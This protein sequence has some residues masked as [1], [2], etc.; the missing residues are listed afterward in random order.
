MRA[1]VT[2][3]LWQVVA[4]V[5]GATFFVGLLAGRYAFP[6]KSVQVRAIETLL[7]GA[8]QPRERSDVEAAQAYVRAAIP[9]L[10]AW[11]ADH[12]GYVGANLQ[13]L[14]VNYDASLTNIHVVWATSQSYCV[15]TMTA[16][17]YHKQGPAGDILPGAC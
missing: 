14:Q 7:Q 16:P 15:E 8:E 17:K 4:V 6:H 3:K 1:V 12:S 13:T 2:L 9:A 11:N 10:E 5:A